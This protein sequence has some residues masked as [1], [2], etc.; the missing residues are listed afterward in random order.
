MEFGGI[1]RIPEKIYLWRNT[2]IK[3]YNSN[4]TSAKSKKVSPIKGGNQLAY[5]GQ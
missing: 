5:G 1:S 3:Y 2:M 4:P